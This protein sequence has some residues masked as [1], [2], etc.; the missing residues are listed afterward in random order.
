NDLA[1]PAAT[2]NGWGSTV[3]AVHSNCG[4]G[5]QLLASSPSDT[6]RPDSVQAIEIAGH[7]ALPVSAP[8]DLSGDVEALW[9]AGNYNQ[10]VNGVM[11][12][13]ANGKYEAFTLT[14]ICNQ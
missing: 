14:V 4:S 12:S 7:E 13:Q 5:W 1:A 6:I 10:V 9:T 8:V 11:H 2:Y 3:A